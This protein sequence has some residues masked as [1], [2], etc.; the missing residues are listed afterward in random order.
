MFKLKLVLLYFALA[1]S[2]LGLCGEG[3]GKITGFVPY[4]VGADEA[5]IIMTQSITGTSACNTTARFAMKSSDPKFKG[6]RA[7]AMAAYLAASP[8]VLRGANTC[9][10]FGNSE[11]LLYMC[12][13]SIPC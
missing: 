5:I 1:A 8:V 4:F 6:T 11:D 3:T 2:S 13:G 9:N 10:T 12:V 7:A